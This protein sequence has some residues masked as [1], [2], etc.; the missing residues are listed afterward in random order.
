MLLCVHT[1]QISE[2]HEGKALFADYS[3]VLE[4]AVPASFGLLD[5]STSD[6]EASTGLFAGH[7]F[8]TTGIQKY[9][10]IYWVFYFRR[11]APWRSAFNG[12]LIAAEEAG[13]RNQWIDRERSV[14]MCMYC[15]AAA[16]VI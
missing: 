3:S 12:M 5:S 1:S 15:P 13:L 9:T 14:Y 10:S 6:L 11:R 4:T 8:I 7:D 2:V 16:P